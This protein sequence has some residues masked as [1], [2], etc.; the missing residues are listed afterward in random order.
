MSVSCNPLKRSLPTTVDGNRVAL[1]SAV[2]S[3]PD[4]VIPHDRIAAE[5][6]KFLAAEAGP[7]QHLAI[8]CRS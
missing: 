4:D 2:G 6:M 3:A 1:F 8:A 5:E 7:D